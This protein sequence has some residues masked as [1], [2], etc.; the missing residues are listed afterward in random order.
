MGEAVTS[1]MEH[2]LR[3]AS[4]KILATIDELQRL[5]A[6][7]RELPPGSE[8]FN[9][10][11]IEVERLAG[12]IFTQSHVQ[13][14]L[15]E[16]SQEVSEQTGAV[17]APID[18]IAATREIPVILAEWREAERKLAEANAD[19]AE[20]ALAAADVRRLR[21]EYQRAHAAQAEAAKADLSS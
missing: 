5:E 3:S 11:A 20:H 8:R 16:R 10:L 13:E 7:K 9:T 17:I 2:A 19:S 6:E 14:Q 1:E 21:D 15:A 18:E 12:S 4:D